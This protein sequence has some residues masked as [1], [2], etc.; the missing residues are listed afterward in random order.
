MSSTVSAHCLCGAIQLE[1]E[2]IG[3]SHQCHCHLCRRFEGS[4]FHAVPVQNLAVVDGAQ[5]PGFFASSPWAER[6]FCQHCG[7]GLIFRTKNLA[8]QALSVGAIDQITTEPDIRQVYVESAE[9]RLD[10]QPDIWQVGARLTGR[11]LLDSMNIDAPVSPPNP[12]ADPEQPQHG[13]CL[14]GGVAFD[15]RP[16][17]RPVR[18]CHC[19]QCQQHSSSWYRATAVQADQLTFHHDSTLKW[20]RSSDFAE[21]GFCNQCGSKPFWRKIID[22]DQ[23]DGRG[24]LSIN[25]GV[26]DHRLPLPIE[27]HIFTDSLRGRPPT[28]EAIGC[29]SFPAGSA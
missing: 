26:F 12:I 5:Q 15:V 14:C 24:A 10:G 22:R 28:D 18:I 27:A 21:R 11:A 4:V 19:R 2:A 1:A 8:W 20:Y 9:M 17:F 29:K 23:P 6:G 3:A 7:S 13:Q 25:T 16:P